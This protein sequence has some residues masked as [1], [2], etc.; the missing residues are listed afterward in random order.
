MPKNIVVFSDGTGQGGGLLPDENR[1]NVYKLFR[2]SRVCPDTVINPAEQ[3]AFYDP[4]LGS[5][6]AGGGIKIGWWR[7]IYNI[8]SSATGLG[9]TQNIIDCYAAIIRVWEPGDRIYL[10]G[11]SRG[12]YTVRCV[13]GVLALCGVP[14][15]GANGAPLKRDRATAGALAR[16]AVKEVYQF[17]NSVKGDPYQPVRINLA[18]RFRARYASAEP[19]NPVLS[20]AFPYFIG[21]WDTVATLGLT[22]RKTIGLVAGAVLLVGVLAV[23]GDLIRAWL[24]SGDRFD[25]RTYWETFGIVCGL[26]LVVGLIA[27]VR[28]YVKFTTRS[29]RPWYETLHVTGWRMQFYDTELS[30]HVQHARHA[31]AIDENRKSFDRVPWT[32][33]PS[34]APQ[35]VTTTEKDGYTQL[36]QMWFAGVHSDIGGSY[37]ENEARLSDIALEWMVNEAA[38]LPHPLIVDRSLLHVWPS[39]A[40]PQHDERKSFAAGLPGWV[41]HLLRALGLYEKANW[42]P[43]ARHVPRN[44]PLHPTVLQ[45]LQLPTVLR[46]DVT[47]P[48]RPQALQNHVQAAHLYPPAN[49]L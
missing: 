7:R 27:W 12:A 13:A 3:V 5:Q 19:T 4:G 42:T 22:T 35:V 21:V 25:A 33:G 49:P 2:A 23:V 48:Y 40:G 8:L 26:G 1:S 31:L 47:E 43:L 41:S 28:T 20:N 44:A 17:G 46:Y 10:V 16:E 34:T 14:T 38:G 15:R 39:A 37:D 6:A 30:Q 24:V 29:S 32:T 9:I 18:Q 11:F 36:I 45:R